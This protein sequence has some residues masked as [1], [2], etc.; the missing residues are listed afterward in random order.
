[1]PELPEVETIKRGLEAA[2]CG[3][4][5]IDVVINNPKVIKAPSADRFSHLL[6][7]MRISRIFRRGKVLIFSLSSKRHKELFLLIHL[8]MSGQL[9]YPGQ[10]IKARVSFKL[11]NGKL[12]D[13]NDQRLLGELKV[14]KR[15]EDSLFLRR[16]GPEPFDLNS[17]DF[18]KM[19]SKRKTRIKPLLLDQSF[20]SGIGNIYAAESLFRAKI[21]P[22]RR[23]ATLTYRQADRLLY[24]IIAVLKEAIKYKGSSVSQYVKS[25]GK[26]GRY[27]LYHKVYNRKGKP[28]FS[29]RS[30]IERISLGGRGTYFC[31]QCQK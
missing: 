13:F 21:S 29:C 30:K 2:I 28:C 19:L 27:A 9:V 18:T 7:G 6:K 16:L 14:L 22:Q 12:L 31:P 11:S 25:D 1:M 26:Q 17:R 5:I 23:A 8:R 3:R 24:S 10:G 15:L 20:I 4:R